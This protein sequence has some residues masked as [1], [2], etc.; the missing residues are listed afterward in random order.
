MIDEKF[1][2]VFNSDVRDEQRKLTIEQ[3]QALFDHMP[4]QRIG[5]LFDFVKW[6]KQALRN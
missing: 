6:T 4:N 2:L 5:D 3:I 1:M